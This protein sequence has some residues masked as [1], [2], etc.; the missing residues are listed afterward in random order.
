M[1]W[2]AI[3]VNLAQIA[4]VLALFI[5]KGLSFGGMTILSFFFLL[6]FALINLIV[7]LFYTIN[8]APDSP[9]FGREKIPIVKRQDLRVNYPPGRRPSLAVGKMSHPIL[10]LAENGMR[11]GLDRN[12]R[13]KRRIKGQITL[14]CGKV[15]DVKASMVRREGDEA[16]LLMNRPMEY[17]LLLQEKQKVQSGG[18]G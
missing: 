5:T 10:D 16:A 11:I 9:R 3:A 17:D 2:L 4:I 18:E 13:I 6:L 1:R 7:L 8:I 15:I 14:L 12:A